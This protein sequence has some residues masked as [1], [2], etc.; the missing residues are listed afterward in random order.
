MVKELK[1]ESKI[2]FFDDREDEL[3]A[4]A[5]LDSDYIKHPKVA[6]N[7][8]IVGPGGV[9]CPYDYNIWVG[10]TN[11]RLKKDELRKVCDN[12]P[13]VECCTLM[14][15]YRFQVLIGKL[16]NGEDVR[17]AIKSSLCQEPPKPQRYIVIIEI[18]KKQKHLIGNSP[19]EVESKIPKE[20][21][22]I[23]KSW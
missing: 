13:G 10:H 6:Y 1:W 11:F 9:D 12:V 2:W 8:L 16:F 5:H 18:D 3:E 19:E 4:K 17:S 23:K 22:V 14:S 20:A 15:E 21:K 7:K